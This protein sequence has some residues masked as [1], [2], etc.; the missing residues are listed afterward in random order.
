MPRCWLFRR[1][2]L[3][4][5]HRLQRRICPW[6]AS[7]WLSTLSQLPLRCCSSVEAA[8]E[9]AAT[10][11]C[12]SSSFGRWSPRRCMGPL[13]RL[14]PLA[15]RGQ[16]GAAASVPAAAAG[17]A[18]PPRAGAPAG[19]GAPP[20]PGGGDAGGAGATAGV[21]PPGGAAGGAAQRGDAPRSW[22]EVASTHH[23]A[24]ARRQVTFWQRAD[25]QRP[26]SRR[27]R[28]RSAERGGAA[29]A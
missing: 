27:G 13:R 2:R 3:W 24:E 4:P 10:P 28:S 29:G 7:R 5:A 14:M 6:P 19:P 8:P 18:A 9:A 23:A 25:R 1:R 15:R 26:T 20:P 22:R 16:G 11:R 21:A 12:S 17:I